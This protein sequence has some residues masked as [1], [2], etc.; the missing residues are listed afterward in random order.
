M[1]SQFTFKLVDRLCQEL[2][3]G[4]GIKTLALHT[5]VK[6][7]LEQIHTETAAFIEAKHKLSKNELDAAP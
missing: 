5:I 7:A 4:D 6:E 3:P 1:Q 2:F